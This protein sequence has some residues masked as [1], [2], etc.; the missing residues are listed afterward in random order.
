LVHAPQR[1]S[2]NFFLKCKNAWV[3]LKARNIFAPSPSSNKVFSI[4]VPWIAHS[5]AAPNTSTTNFFPFNFLSFKIFPIWFFF[6]FNF[7]SFLLLIFFS[8]CKEKINW[9][10]FFY[11][12]WKLGDDDCFLFQVGLNFLI[13]ACL[14]L[15]FKNALKK[16]I[17]LFFFFT[18][19]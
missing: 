18:S 19:N 13:K 1:V 10:D 5:R 9:C 3:G 11:I 8:Y 6:L 15:R 2:N 12:V 4:V 7:F 14:F 17:F 16:F